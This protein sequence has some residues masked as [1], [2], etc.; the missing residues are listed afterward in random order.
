MSHKFGIANSNGFVWKV[1]IPIAKLK[2]YR[3][4]S[5]EVGGVCVFSDRP[6][7]LMFKWDSCTA[8]HNH[9]LG[10]RNIQR[11]DF[12]AIVAN[13]VDCMIGVRVTAAQMLPMSTLEAEQPNVVT[14]CG[15]A[16]MA[17]L[18]Y[19]STEIL[20]QNCWVCGS[21]YLIYGKHSAICQPKCTSVPYPERMEHY[22]SSYQID[23]LRIIKHG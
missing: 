21:R 6:N 7:W 18:V 12:R 17:N 16:F 10:L 11:G 14:L 13:K 1:C 23:Y 4:Y 9:T 15:F 8:S 2:G 20:S 3:S 5:V 19:P 22:L